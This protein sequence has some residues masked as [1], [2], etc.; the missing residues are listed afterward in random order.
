MGRARAIW[1]AFWELVDSDSVRPFIWLYYIPLLLW[2]I[3]AVGWAEPIPTLQPIIGGWI[4]EVW[5]WMPI[6]GTLA[7]MVGLGIRHGG[8]AVS[9]MSAPL[10][11][12]DWLGLWLQATSHAC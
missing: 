5:E 4:Y 2:G 10:L 11:F 6:P 8:T 9:Q 12:R 7:C 1:A 3:Y